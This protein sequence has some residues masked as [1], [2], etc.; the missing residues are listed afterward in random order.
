MRRF[1]TNDVDLIRMSLKGDNMAFAE[2][3]RRHDRAVFG[4]IARYVDNAEDAKDLYQEVFLRVHRKL[5]DFQFRSEFSTWVYRITVNICLDHAKSVRR[6]VLANAEPMRT[7]RSDGSEHEKEPISLSP[8]PEQHSIDAEVA[9]RIRKAM[10]VLPP[11]QRMTFVL[12]HDE[13]RSI[14]EIA[15]TLGCGEGT[16]KRYLYEATRTMRVELKDLLHPGSAERVNR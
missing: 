16:I 5:K 10:L 9:G 7:E 8:G 11:R 1:D 12:R 3:V 2:L 4:L 13:G 15:Q 6:S 14:K